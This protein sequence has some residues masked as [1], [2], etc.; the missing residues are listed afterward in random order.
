M[1]NPKISQPSKLFLTVFFS[2]RIIMV[3]RTNVRITVKMNRIKKIDIDACKASKSK[4]NNLI[5]IQF[6][7][8]NAFEP[9]KM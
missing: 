9:I 8:K 3:T 4:K 1:I 2:A 7:F 6:L 5:R